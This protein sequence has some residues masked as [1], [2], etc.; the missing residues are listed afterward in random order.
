MSAQFPLRDFL[1]RL[2]AEGIR[3]RVRDYRRIAQ[4]LQGS[5]PWTRRRLRDT[6][7]VLLTK[8]EHQ[9][10]LL[11]R[12]F[13][14]YFSLSSAEVEAVAEAIDTQAFLND[15]RNLEAA[16][17]RPPV[18]SPLPPTPIPP[19][20]PDQP[21][22]RSRSRSA[23]LLLILALITGLAIWYYWPR[24][25]PAQVVDPTAPQPRAE[26]PSGQEDELETR[27][28]ETRT[29]ETQPDK[30]QTDET[31]TDKTRTYKKVPY[32][33]DIQNV[34][35]PQLDATWKKPAW[36]SGALLSGALLLLL[37]AYPVYLG[38][39]A[40]LVY[41]GFNRK[42]RFPA[43]LEWDADKPRR[44]SLAQ[45]GGG[46]APLL[47]RDTLDEAADAVSYFQ[48]DRP[49]ATLDVPATIQATL[50]QG[51]L[52]ALR[53]HR[54][55]H[56]RT[57]LI[58]RDRRARASWN[59]TAEELAVGIGQRGVPVV[60]GAFKG[61]P[62]RFRVEHGGVGHLEDLEETRAAFIILIFSDGSR[63]RPSPAWTDLK[64]WPQCA[65]LDYREPRRWSPE[66][67]ARRYGL[68][69]YT[70]DAQGIG[71]ALKGFL[72]EWGART[73]AP[74]VAAPI[75]RGE[76]TDAA[77]ASRLGDTLSWAQDC[78][79]LHP[80]SRGLADRLRRRFYPHL[81][82]TR[83]ERMLDLPGTWQ[84]A[85]GI[86]FAPAA[87][88]LLKQGFVTRPEKNRREVLEF[89]RDELDQAGRE[90]EAGGL[91]R[92]DWQSRRALLDLEL[93][94]PTPE[95]AALARTPALAAALSN[96]LQ[97]FGLSG[98]ADS[99][100]ADK[101]PLANQPS[102]EIL[103]SLTWLPDSPLQ[104]KRRRYHPL[105]SG[106]R[107][108]AGLI[109]TALLAMIAWSL[110]LAVQSVPQPEPNWR[111]EGVDALALLQEQP[112]E[113]AGEPADG[114]R[115]MVSDLP[116][117]LRLKPDTDYRLRLFGGGYW[118]DYAFRVSEGQEA[119][120]LVAEREIERPCMEEITAGLQAIICLQDGT[121]PPQSWR[122]RL[123]A[124]DVPDKPLG[125]QLSIGI[126]IAEDPEST[127]D[128]WSG[129][130][131]LLATGSLDA[132]FR[133]YPTAG[134]AVLDRMPVLLEQL[135]I[136]ATQA[137]W[138]LEDPSA[139]FLSEPDR[140]A[141][142]AAL[143]SFA[144]AGSLRWDSASLVALFQPGSTPDISEDELIAALRLDP[145]DFSGNG[146][147]L[148]LFRPLATAEP[149]KS[150]PKDPAPDYANWKILWKVK[151]HSEYIAW[152][153]GVAF[154]PDGRSVL[155]GS[156]DS[157]M[158]LWDLSSGQKIR[159]FSGPSGV[160]AIALAPDGR[161]ALSGGVDNTLRLWDLISG[162]EIRT[163]TG[164]SN[165]VHAI[166]FSPDGRSVLSGSWDNTLKL[167]DLNSGK[168]L[169]TFTGHSDVVYS[170]AFAPDG[171]RALSGSRDNTL[172]LWDLSSGK[173]IRTFSG[174]SGSVM[175]VAFAPDGRSVLSGGVDDTMR[176]WDLISGK[177][178]RTFSG[179]SDAVFSVAFAPD[180]RSVLSGSGD[181]TLKLWDL[182][183]GKEI[184]TLSGHS[185]GISS[186]AFAPDGR[187]AVSG[188]SDGY[189][190]LWGAE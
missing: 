177:E 59:R 184:R 65:W 106:Q 182:S 70:A 134:K 52:P 142:D 78:S 181:G 84:D 135:P 80:C 48:S 186:V 42:I 158:K 19:E 137:L 29:D 160:F 110:W 27:T 107:L 18:S 14:R 141:L 129:Y 171:R 28:D 112:Q 30:T 190:I 172:K 77:L 1:L 12:Q 35:L 155:S 7:A 132:I 25:D 99:G 103:Q 169:R 66:H 40:Y 180:G 38:L 56:I 21:D 108:V 104:Q 118:Q 163:F 75:V 31:R 170:V 82:A 90:L 149:P 176:L 5:G 55:R 68:P 23:W 105:R 161:R 173:E 11:L 46:P 89:I 94:R 22:S 36:A 45:V 153:Q 148:L 85:E 51:G 146:D 120:L 4:A 9:Q 157:T 151:A 73:Q 39:I 101:I 79:V 168:K 62:A 102:P 43:P 127:P 174:H 189:L 67:P 97:E 152:P 122:E 53:F 143:G 86:R 140:S 131:P 178:I 37:I 121:T 164:H 154:A 185:N 144:R 32:V 98:G 24:P 111:V 81:A 109:G 83:L 16:P 20:V 69:L 26:S 64:Q 183:S 57:L 113:N 8:S 124:T 41:P 147:P 50:D 33:E 136:S 74:D 3:V 138:W 150:A 58:L 119:R 116:A 166:A 88:R 72:S 187:R 165:A 63:I 76:L 44:F 49:A 125:R 167:W 156:D 188:D 91:A 126:E 159:T 123:E 96:R 114:I 95:L 115:G 61:S 117:E 93:G 13:D 133:L 130:D 54:R 2:D 179:H 128:H 175:S 34:S 6:L 100:E 71:A 145:D 87:R 15:L 47:D 139:T 162:K 10:N 60:L 17:D 92:L